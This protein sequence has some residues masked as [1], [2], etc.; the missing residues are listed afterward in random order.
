MR[1]QV[2]NANAEVAEQGMPYHFSMADIAKASAQL[3][4]ICSTYS[5]GQSVYK[6]K[7]AGPLERFKTRFTQLLSRLGCVARIPHPAIEFGC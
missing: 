1:A 5:A 6:R 7:Y 4:A 2:L 3:S